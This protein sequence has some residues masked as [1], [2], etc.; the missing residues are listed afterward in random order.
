M[1]RPVASCNSAQRAKERMTYISFHPVCRDASRRE[2]VRLIIKRFR[3]PDSWLFG[4]NHLHWFARR[5]GVE[6]PPL[7]LRWMKDHRRS[8]LSRKAAAAE[9]ATPINRPP[10]SASIN[11]CWMVEILPKL[12]IL[13]GVIRDM[14]K[15]KSPSVHYAVSLGVKSCPELEF[16]HFNVIS[17]MSPEM[18]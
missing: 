3:K 18:I 11:C 16:R 12:P 8:G 9:L 2:L 1:H 6:P 7:S 14:Q 15:A 5:Q 4:Y 17:D 13:P 10:P